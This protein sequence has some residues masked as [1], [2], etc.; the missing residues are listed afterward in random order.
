MFTN[1]NKLIGVI[2]A[3]V[4]AVLLVS[5]AVALI[6]DNANKNELAQQNAQLQEKL[7]KVQADLDA[8]EE[9]LNAA[10]GDLDSAIKTIEELDKALTAAKTDLASAKGDLADARQ[11]VADLE[12]KI[13]ELVTSWAAATPEVHGAVVEIQAAYDEAMKNAYLY[14]DAKALDGLYEAKMDAIYAVIRSTSVESLKA[15][16]EG[17]NDAIAEIEKDRFDNTLKDMIEA[18]KVDGVTH[19][20]DVAGVEGCEKYLADLTSNTEV[21]NK[22]VELGLDKEVEELRKLLNADEKADL[23]K[24]FIDAVALIPEYVQLSDKATVEA[25][26]AAYDA[27]NSK[28]PVVA[29]ENADVDEAIKTLLEAEQRLLALVDIVDEANKINEAIKSATAVA[30]ADSA[31]RDAIKNIGDRIA[32]WEKLVEEADPNWTL[33]DRAGYEALKTLYNNAVEALKADYDA[34]KAAV[35]AIGA[36]TPDSGAAI[37]AAWAANTK[38]TANVEFKEILGDYAV[39]Y[40]ALLDTLKKADATYKALN[41]LIDRIRKAIDALYNA[42]PITVKDT[43]LTAL[44]ALITELTVDYA[45]KLE[46]INTAEVDYVARLEYVRLIPHKNAAIKAVEVAY[47][48]Y[49]AKVGT[50]FGGQYNLYY[51]LSVVN[52]QLHQD[53]LGATTRDAIQAIVDGIDAA[54]ADCLK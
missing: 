7:D 32:A 11:R 10:K 14:A 22:L 36:V 53:I 30:K 41:D 15:V 29:G 42:D 18:V 44:E 26:R 4:V 43:D 6:A 25:A 34:F 54:F 12:A 13:L 20:E 28:Y 16:V 33:I 8:A 23:E 21:Y 47:A 2:A 51:E 5:A 40:D 46:V 35:E 3:I 52:S 39:G 45:Q 49:Q 37:D 38:L 9:K 27:L 31:T 17:F 50:D 19:P 24:A 1:K 48:E